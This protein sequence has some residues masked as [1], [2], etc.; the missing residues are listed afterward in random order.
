MRITKEE[1]AR[2]RSGHPAALRA[3]QPIVVKCARAGCV[4]AGELSAAFVEDVTQELWMIFLGSVGERFNPEY[5]V[6]PWLIEAARRI[7]LALRRK[8]Q[9]ETVASDCNGLASD[10]DA[11]MDGILS[12][13]NDGEE[14][15]EAKR[16]S[17]K[18]FDDVEVDIDREQ[19]L[20][21]LMKK[22]N[23]IEKLAMH[24]VATEPASD[25]RPTSSPDVGRAPRKPSKAHLSSVYAT[26]LHNIRTTLC[27][28][29]EEM[30]TRLG[31]KVATYQAYEY[32]RIK[33]VPDAIMERARAL[34]HDQDY[35]YVVEKFKGKT[36]RDIVHEWA[37]RMHTE[38][39]VSNM[40][41]LLG[42]NKSTVSRWLSLDSEPSPYELV[43]FEDIVEQ[44]VRRI[45]RAA[46]AAGQNLGEE[47]ETK[48]V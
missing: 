41:R 11:S 12:F 22:C 44:Q 46:Q 38:P 2:V 19:A 15:P 35:S 17:T 21:Y 4:K 26:E 47:R 16:G 14:A 18:S 28:T 8:T 33:A 48:D 10:E 25:V 3:L 32:G 30:A 23:R 6:E 7:A 13:L 27:F 39:S 20:Q 9:R 36:M 1:L 37:K 40:A 42:V 45:E 29:H 34:L 43:R 5:N 31:L 24:V